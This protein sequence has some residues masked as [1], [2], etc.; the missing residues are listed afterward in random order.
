MF[1]PNSRVRVYQLF[2]VIGQEISFHFSRTATS[3][4]LRPLR[5]LL[6]AARMA[7]T[8]SSQS[9]VRAL[10]ATSDPLPDGL[11]KIE[12]ARHAWDDAS[13]Y[14]PSKAELIVDWI[15]IKFS[16]ERSKDPYVERLG[17]IIRLQMYLQIDEPPS[18]PSLLETTLRHHLNSRYRL[19]HP[20]G[21]P[22]QD[23]ATYTP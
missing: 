2:H 1:N 12:I 15:L 3:S 8:Q 13:F 7:T 6:L 22:F 23:L 17:P 4:S 21:P 18:G 5:G 11:Y 9:F 20:P 19:D 16:K 10:K 14:I